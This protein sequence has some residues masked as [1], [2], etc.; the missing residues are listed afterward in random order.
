MPAQIPVK[1]ID[2]FRLLDRSD[3]LCRFQA[4]H[5]VMDNFTLRDY[6]VWGSENDSMA[7]VKEVVD[8]HGTVVIAAV[9]YLTIHSDHVKVEMIARN[10]LPE[11]DIYKGA[12]FDLLLFIEMNIARANG[13]NEVRLHAVEGMPDQYKRKGYEEIAGAAF[14]DEKWGT[15]T[16]MK[17][18]V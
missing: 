1:F 5:P 16:P 18:H 4:N 11:Y 17:K 7:V 13:F 14:D 8:D 12:G 15:L 6:F 9:A 3:L 10:R 2:G